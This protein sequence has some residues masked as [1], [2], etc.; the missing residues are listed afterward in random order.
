[1]ITTREFINSLVDAWKE[2]D[3]ECEDCILGEYVNIFGR[4][5]ILCRIISQACNEAILEYKKANGIK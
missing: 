3:E 1:M 2:C 5:I 4:E